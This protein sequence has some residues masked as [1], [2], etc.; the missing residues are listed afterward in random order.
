MDIN[1]ID[2][3]KNYQIFIT[4]SIS[5]FAI[6]NNVN[7]LIKKFSDIKTIEKNV[8]NLY[9]INSDSELRYNGINWVKITENENEGMEIVEQRKKKLINKFGGNIKVIKYLIKSEQI[10]KSD[11]YTYL[12][13]NEI[14]YRHTIEEGIKNE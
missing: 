8:K 11:E 13:D 10:N 9:C 12:N 5:E 1:S 2:D 7:D 4:D 14:I 3:L 6:Y